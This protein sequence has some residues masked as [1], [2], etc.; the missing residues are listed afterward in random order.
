M[1]KNKILII[2]AHPS[3]KSFCSSLAESYFEGAKS[4]NY[5]AE[6][7]K[8]RDLR[9]DLSL[10]QGYQ[11]I[12][13]LEEDLIKAQKMIKD[14]QHLVIVYP[15]WWGTM[16]A[17]LK[18]FLDRAWLPGF[19]FKYHDNNPFWDRLLSGRS[20]RMIVTSDSPSLYNLLTNFNAPY[21]VMKNNVLKFC[22]FKPVKMTIVDRVKYLQPEKRQK[23]LNKL[24]KLGSEGR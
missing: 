3:E 15:L 17:L 9:F 13:D 20:A 19:A 21:R 18:G 10:H 6:L 14:C 4:S 12:Q 7:L 24:F 1:P 22:G 5:P 11:E 23:H 2:D 16:P 8:L